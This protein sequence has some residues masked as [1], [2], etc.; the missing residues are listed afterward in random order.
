M[1]SV[2]KPSPLDTDLTEEE[3]RRVYD[4]KER[5]DEELELF[6]SDTEQGWWSEAVLPPPH[7]E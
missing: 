3:L 2:R 7:N 1:E 4:E 6:M 5:E